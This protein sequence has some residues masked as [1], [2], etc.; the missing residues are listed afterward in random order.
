M[1]GTKSRMSMYRKISSFLE[2]GV[3]LHDILK[4]LSVQYKKQSERDIRAQILDK[5]MTGLSAG[6]SFS[7]ILSEN[8]RKRIVH[9]DLK[10][11]NIHFCDYKW[12]VVCVYITIFFVT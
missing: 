11:S 1:F 6:R 8:H 10:P 5:W 12:F 4:Q 2:E 9:H 7:G 3:P